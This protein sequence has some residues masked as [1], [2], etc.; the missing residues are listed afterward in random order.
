MLA[1]SVFVV[2]VGLGVPEFVP[3]PSPYSYEWWREEEVPSDMS[4]D[5]EAE[6]AFRCLIEGML[7]ESLGGS[8]LD[9]PEKVR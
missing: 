2:S 5:D 9:E 6:E 7:L 4:F 3:P 8:F 1:E